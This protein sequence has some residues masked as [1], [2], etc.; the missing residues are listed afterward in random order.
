MYDFKKEILQIQTAFGKWPKAKKIVLVALLS[1]IGAIFQ[2]AGGYLPAVGYFISPL[3]TAPVILCSIF[4][5]PIGF[6]SYILITLLLFILEP[7]E[8]IIFPFTTGLLGLF[9]GGSFHLFKG[10]WSQVLCG[11]AGLIIGISVLLYAVKFPVLGPAVSSSFSF[12][13]FAAVFICSIFYSWIWVAL[14]RKL[15]GRFK[16]IIFLSPSK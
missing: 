10:I 12:L 3:A 7:S 9:I 1:S 4:S 15:L 11:A 8:L 16:R 13:V 5:I 2:S 14:I 6:L